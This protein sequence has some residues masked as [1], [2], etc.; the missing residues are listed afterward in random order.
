MQE[1]RLQHLCTLDIMVGRMQA[2]GAGPQGERRI[3]E[4]TGGTF[5]GPRLNGRILPGG[6]DWILVRSDGVTQLDVR[7]TLETNDGALIYLSYRGLR[8]GPPEVMEKLAR[9]ETVSPSDYYFRTTPVFETGAPAYLWLNKIIAVGTG[10]R[11]PTGPV[12]TIYEVV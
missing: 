4:V 10:D 12:Y 6:A 2:I 8:H 11:R 1:L 9:G 5:Q 7:V 3:A